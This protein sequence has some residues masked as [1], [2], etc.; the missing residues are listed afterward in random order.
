VEL[1]DSWGWRG[2]FGLLVIDT[3]PVAEVECRAMLPAGVSTH[4]ARFASPRPTGSSD[5]GA[6]PA[7]AVADS[8]DIARGL[9]ELGRMRLDAICLCFTSSSFFGGYG[10]DDRFAADATRRAHGRPVTT[11]ALATVAAMRTLGVRRP[12]LVVPPWF[13]DAILEAALGYLAGAG[14]DVAGHLRFDLG[15]GWR[16]LPPW[17]VWDHGGQWE[18]RPDEVYRQVRAT[19]PPDADGIVVAGNGFRAGEAIEALEADLGVAVVTSNQASMWHCLGI[20]GI[21]VPVPGAGRLLAL[22][23]WERRSAQPVA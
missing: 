8:P 16:D 12:Y 7:R 22:P 3:D 9:D 20:A 15:L 6:D 10:F 14:V 13:K 19:L 21:A 1:A 2:R 23:R 4:V 17:E 11:A 18:V 5:Y